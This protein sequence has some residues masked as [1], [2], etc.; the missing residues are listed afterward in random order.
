MAF[1]FSA[2]TQELKSVLILSIY[3]PLRKSI[4][5]DIYADDTN[6]QNEKQITRA[7]LISL[8]VHF[9]PI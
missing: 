9:A 1:L 7:M 8:L 6:A 2:F 3:Q 4:K 5:K